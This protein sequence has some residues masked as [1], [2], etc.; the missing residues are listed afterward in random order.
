MENRSQ[1]V[2]KKNL[3]DRFLFLKKYCIMKDKCP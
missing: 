3:A 1:M 2:R